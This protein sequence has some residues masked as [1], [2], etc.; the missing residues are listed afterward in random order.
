M[1]LG[2][3]PFG[4]DGG[5]INAMPDERMRPLQWRKIDMARVMRLWNI[6]TRDA[7]AKRCR[8]YVINHLMS[9]E[10]EVLN[11]DG[12]VMAFDSGFANFFQHKYKEFC[13]AAYDMY[14]V[15]GVVPVV[16]MQHANGQFFPVV[17]KI[18]TFELETAYAIDTEKLYF[19]VRR[20]KALKVWRDEADPNVGMPARYAANRMRENVHVIHTGETPPAA[21]GVNGLGTGVAPGDAGWIVDGSVSVI[22]GLGADPSIEGELCSPLA[23]IEQDIVRADNLLRFM[24]MGQYRMVN[25]PMT[26]QYHKT[27]NPDTLDQYR[28]MVGGAGYDPDTIFSS[29]DAHNVVATDAQ[30][31]AVRM[32]LHF[33]SMEDQHNSGMD[34]EKSTPADAV[35]VTT[36]EGTV[37][38]PKGLEYVKN[39]SNVTQVGAHYPFVRSQA[40]DNT[41]GVYGIPMPLLR[42]AGALRGNIAGQND[43]FRNTLVKNADML[44]GIC[45]AVFMEIFAKDKGKY[46]E[47]MFGRKAAVDDTQFVRFGIEEARKSGLEVIEDA[48]GMLAPPPAVEHVITGDETGEETL[49][50]DQS[51]ESPEQVARAIAELVRKNEEANARALVKWEGKTDPGRRPEEGRR[52]WEMDSVDGVD[53]Y[54]GYQVKINVTH[55]MNDKMIEHAFSIGAMSLHTY[56][57]VILSRLGYSASQLKKPPTDAQK[58][59]G[60][61]MRNPGNEAP[62]EDVYQPDGVGLQTASTNKRNRTVPTGILLEVAAAGGD[63]DKWEAARKQKEN[64]ARAKAKQAVAKKRKATSASKGKP[65]KKR[66][67]S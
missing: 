39:D 63:L 55:M 42:N 52:G 1:N 28:P 51:G 38:V 17:P 16:I 43:I 6:H 3:G 37:V 20:Q 35:R 64:E 47:A 19:R 33:R 34:M 22:T 29:P 18:G 10:L 12:E 27:E 25:P 56:Q 14:M 48:S 5:I 44:G 65:A 26:M 23:S 8:D 46:F 2:A 9:S 4:V 13:I 45:T 60:D 49:E 62:R 7:L 61:L 11:G 15:L 31:R 32:H 30:L 36:G 21:Q 66:K 67:T 50:T 53:E 40:D 41:T 58:L 24:M 57:N 54:A 59:I